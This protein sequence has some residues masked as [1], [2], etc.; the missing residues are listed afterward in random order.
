MQKLVD[1]RS[2]YCVLPADDVADLLLTSDLSGE[3]VA[4]PLVGTGS[5]SRE[6]PPDK[7]HP[8]RARHVH[9]HG[10]SRV[11]N[12]ES[13]VDDDSKSSDLLNDDFVSYSKLNQLGACLQAK[14]LH[15]SILM[16]S[17]RSWSNF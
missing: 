12:S 4:P 13:S 3:R 14:I 16:K 9:L 6:V 5:F 17:H 15:H 8:G 1:A 7:S 11:R 10:I 2:R